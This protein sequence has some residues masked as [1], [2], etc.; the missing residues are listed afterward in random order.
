MPFASVSR[1]FGFLQ[2]LRINSPQRV[3]FNVRVPVPSVLYRVSGQ[4]PARRRVVVPVAQQLQT[5]IRVGLVAPI[6]RKPKRTHKRPAWAVDIPE[7]IVLPA[8]RGPLRDARLPENRTHPVLV[9]IG[10]DDTDIP[11]ADSRATA[12][13]AN[14]DVF[15]YARTSH[16]GPL[17]G[18]RA[19][20]IATNT[21]R[22]IE[23]RK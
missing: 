8:R 21:L 10:R 18:R 9:V 5:R 22:W 23:S 19:T 2:T 17:M 1:K 4:E 14:A 16:V 3:V 20:E 6:P 13:W 12:A 15:E 7:R 11:P